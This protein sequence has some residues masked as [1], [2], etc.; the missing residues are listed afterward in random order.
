M[1]GIFW[2]YL[3]KRQIGNFV[4]QAQITKDYFLL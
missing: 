1:G 3:P 2:F 4:S